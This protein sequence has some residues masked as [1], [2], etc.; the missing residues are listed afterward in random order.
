MSLG[1]PSSSF[2]VSGSP[3]G[4]GGAGVF[5]FRNSSPSNGA[6]LSYPPADLPVRFLL[7]FV[8]SGF[9][10]LTEPTVYKNSVL[11]VRRL[12]RGVIFE[13]LAFIDFF[14]YSAI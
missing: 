8:D 4:G 12:A 6:P 14:Q 2:A 7:S 9:R 5:D 1:P 10:C 11:A 3:T 13:L